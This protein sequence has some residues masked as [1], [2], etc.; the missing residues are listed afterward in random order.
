VSGTPLSVVVPALDEAPVLAATLERLRPMRARGA[1]VIVVDGGSADG[2]REVASALADRVLA[3]PRGRASQQNAGAAA[4]RGAVLLFLHADTLLPADADRL[5]LD[6]LARAGR[7]WGRFDVRLSGSHPLLRLT[8]RL[9]GLRSRLTGIATG[10]QAIFV[11]RDRFEA[12]GGFPAIPL[13]EDVALS[14]A[15]RRTGPPL[16]LRQ[17]VVTSSRRWEER[18]I[19]RTILL[20]W[21]LRLAFALGADPVRL[22]ERYR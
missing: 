14:R 3:A 6:G 10:D 2:T 7:G 19:A 4:A 1:E 15:L 21:R 16:C 9:I 20:M 17:R 5:V 18:G 12:V 11:R 22:A 8:G 13:M